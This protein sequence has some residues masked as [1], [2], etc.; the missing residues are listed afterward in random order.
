MFLEVLSKRRA[1]L[2]SKCLKIKFL[3]QPKLEL[4]IFMQKK[5]MLFNRMKFVQP[6]DTNYYFP[7]YLGEFPLFKVSLL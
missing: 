3:V 6:Y 7:L 1:K 2:L 4:A 5:N